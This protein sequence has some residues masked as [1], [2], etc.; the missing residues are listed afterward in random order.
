MVHRIFRKHW[1]I[2]ILHKCIPSNDSMM[3]I[4]LF[5]FLSITL[6]LSLSVCLYFKKITLL[7]SLTFHLYAAQC[8]WLYMNVFHL[9]AYF[10]WSYFE[11]DWFAWKTVSAAVVCWAAYL[12]SYCCYCYWR[13]S[14]Q[15][16]HY[17]FL[18]RHS[19]WTVMW[20]AFLAMQSETAN[21]NERLDVFD[22]TH[23][24][25]PKM[26]PNAENRTQ[27]LNVA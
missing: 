5:F 1:S 3:L 21:Q 20:A 6:C 14:H 11:W 19:S 27:I 17:L 26:Q 25:L 22:A 16:I 23:C 4:R 12:R 10:D 9:A 15:S 13:L 8:W 24:P 7:S 18:N 2:F